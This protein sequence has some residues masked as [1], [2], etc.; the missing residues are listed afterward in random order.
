MIWW[1]LGALPLMPLRLGMPEFEINTTTMQSLM[2][3]L[4]FG[5]V[6]AGTLWAV[7]RKTQPAN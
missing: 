7:R 4:L 1:V 3:H 5:L 6:T 2:G